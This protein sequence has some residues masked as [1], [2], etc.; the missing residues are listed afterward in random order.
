MSMK[1]RLAK[2]T[3]GLLNPIVENIHSREQPSPTPKT[4]PGQMLAFRAQMLE[5]G[6]QVENLELRLKEFE[7]SAP[8]LLIDPAAIKP[9]KWAN[10]HEMS[11]S[12]SEFVQLKKEIELAKGNIQPIKVRPIQGRAGEYELV[13]G[14]R[15][16]RACSELGLKVLSLVEERSDRDLFREM[17]VENREQNSPSGWEQGVKYRKALESGLYASLRQMAADIGVDAGNASKAIAVANLPEEVIQAFPSAL[18]IQYVWG[19]KLSDRLQSD[20]E[21]V[22]REAKRLVDDKVTKGKLSAKQVFDRL[23]ATNVS[24]AVTRKI[25]RNGKPWAVISARGRKVTVEFEKQE[26]AEEQ[27]NDLEKW[28]NALSKA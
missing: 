9:S 2:K 14:H 28:L 17:E 15:R 23:M 11:F 27:I 19:P 13:F 24:A 7:G 26:M 21:S 22:L 6:A 12:T 8:C 25:V 18:T 5:S 20:P 10:R 16:H 1:D 3:E 4:G